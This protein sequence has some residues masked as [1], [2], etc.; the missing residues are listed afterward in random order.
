M[1]E[2]YW[3]P[4]SDGIPILEVF[5]FPVTLSGQDSESNGASPGET[6]N[7]SRVAPVCLCVT[8]IIFNFFVGERIESKQNPTKAADVCHM[9]IYYIYINA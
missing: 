6:N 1:S 2:S 8:S 5:C 9:A 4:V 3:N 7:M